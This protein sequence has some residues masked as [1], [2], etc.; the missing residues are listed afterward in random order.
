M[1]SQNFQK[2]IRV[3]TAKNIDYYRAL[4]TKAEKRIA[5]LKKSKSLNTIDIETVLTQEGYSRRDFM[6][7]VSATTATL[8]LPGFFEPLVAQT[9]QVINR[10]PVIWRNF[11][12]CAGN[13]EALLRSDGPTFDELILDV[14]SLEFHELL[15]APSGHNAELQL[16]EVMQT[17][18]DEYLLFVEGSIPVAQNGIFGTT[19]ASG[20]TY[21]DHL[22]RVSADA[23]AVIAVGSCSSFGGVPAG[24]GSLTGATGVMEVIVDKPVVNIPACPANPSTMLGVILMYVMTGEL[25][26]LDELKRPAFAYGVRIHDACERREHFDAGNFVEEWGDNGAQSGYCLFKMGCKGPYTFNNCPT[27]KFNSSTSWPV[28]AGHGCIGCSEPGFVDKFGRF[29]A[30]TPYKKE[31]N[32]ASDLRIGVAAGIATLGA[33]R[34]LKI[35]GLKELKDGN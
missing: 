6:K 9:I 28:Q 23:A 10:V 33:L 4:Y 17:Y 20:E 15:M 22:K 5:Y 35:D 21:V 16:E 34:E 26:E 27:A 24:E 12:D 11:Q 18:K 25:P 3:D 29:E 31:Y 1:D 19:G 8:M 2:G 32:P 14:I 30:A 13:S 7:W